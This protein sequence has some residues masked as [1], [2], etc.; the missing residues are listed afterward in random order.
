[1]DFDQL[2]EKTKYFNSWDAIYWLSYLS[3]Q[4]EEQQNQ[5]ILE[6]ELQKNIKSF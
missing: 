5:I 3:S 1:M 4:F 6:I 2:F